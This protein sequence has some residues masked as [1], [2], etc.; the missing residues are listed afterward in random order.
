MVSWHTQAFVIMDCISFVNVCPYIIDII[1][2][3]HFSL[4]ALKVEINS[5]HLDAL[6]SLLAYHPCESILEMLLPRSNYHWLIGW[7]VTW[8]LNGAGEGFYH[9]RRNWQFDHLNSGKWQLQ[10]WLQGFDWAHSSEGVWKSPQVLVHKLPE[11][12]TCYCTYLL[13]PTSDT[14]IS[15]DVH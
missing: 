12:K 4:W 5:L 15:L 6:M 3:I 11:T 9:R 14:V 7:V 10:P 1:Y 8:Y 13:C 2:G